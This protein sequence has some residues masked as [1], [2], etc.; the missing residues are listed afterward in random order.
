VLV[1]VALVHL[2]L[3]APPR[4]QAS[5]SASHYLA[6]AGAIADEGLSVFTSSVAP[7]F[8]VHRGV[9]LV[10]LAA[11]AAL[12]AAFARSSGTGA[13]D[14][15][16]IRRCVWIF[17]VG[18]VGV[19]AGYAIYL[20]SAAK[21]YLPLHTGE[22]NRVNVVAALPMSA[23]IAAS[24]SLVAAVVSMGRLSSRRSTVVYIGLVAVTAGLFCAHLRSD[25]AIWIA[26]AQRQNAVLSAMRTISRPPQDS[27]IVVFASPGYVHRIRRFGNLRLN[28]AVP[29]FS[30]WWE[31]LGA[32]R[33]RAYPS[34]TVAAYYM[35]QSSRLVCRP[36][37]AYYVAYDGVLRAMEYGRL[38]F[39]DPVHRNA[40]AVTTQ[41]GCA[42][43]QRQFAPG[44][45]A[46]DF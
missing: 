34:G 3:T 36:R 46:E 41:A 25:E 21:S 7:L 1:L 8:S 11:V 9:V 26:A 30:T 39:I 13:A 10:V 31:T 22:G 32:A 4:R 29:V 40:A 42:S 33:V 38:Y 14:A 43:A 20:P 24:L 17:C 44:P 28:T 37:R 18:V 5:G 15:I 23:L 45:Y 12:C 19:A 2:A 6:R 35:S 27:A 16:R